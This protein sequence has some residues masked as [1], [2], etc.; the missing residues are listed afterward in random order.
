M[1]FLSLYLVKELNFSL[2]DA[3]WLLAFHGI[4][5]FI[6]SYLG[7]YFTD[8]IGHYPVQLGSLVLSGMAFFILMYMTNFYTLGLGM[9]MTAVCTDAYR[10]ANMA[11]IAEFAPPEV[12]TRSIGLLRL[13]INLGFAAGP[14]MGGFI[15]YTYG[16]DWLFIFDGVTCFLAAMLL[17]YILPWRDHMKTEET[18]ASGEMTPPPYKDKP[19]M[20][21]LIATMCT[22]L[23]FFQLFHTIPVYFEEELGLNEKYIG[24]LMAANGLL[25]AVV[26]IPLIQYLEKKSYTYSL[27]MYGA[28]LF[29]VAFGLLVFGEYVF[30][31]WSFIVLVSFAEIINFPFVTTLILNRSPD[32]ARGRYMAYYNMAYSLILI[33]VPLVGFNVADNFGYRWL[34]IGC[35]VVSIFVFFGLWKLRGEMDVPP[36][37]V[38]K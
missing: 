15:A 4:G 1:P 9:L 17:V 26:E 16:Y 2:A 6:G 33:A 38:S 11:S 14:T 35:F 23:V 21:F 27:I 8:R 13:A 31:A 32:K 5:S 30:L 37:N 25:I 28:L 19:Y 22:G 24:W 34:W 36:R 20:F 18:T 12:R 29:G 7:G 3:G 10:P